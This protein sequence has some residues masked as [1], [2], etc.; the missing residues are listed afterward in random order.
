MEKRKPINPEHSEQNFP[1]H[2]QIHPGKNALNPLK[3]HNKAKKLKIIRDKPYHQ[4]DLSKH[5]HECVRREH[6]FLIIL[7]NNYY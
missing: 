1:R 4:H 7:S 6:E 2:R 3:M 5:L